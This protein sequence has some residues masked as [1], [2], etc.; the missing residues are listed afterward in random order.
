MKI[1]RFLPKFEGFHVVSKVII[2][3]FTLGWARAIVIF[4]FIF[5][6]NK[7]IWSNTIIRQR[8]SIRIHQQMECGMVGIV[9]YLSIGLI[10]NSWIYA[11]PAIF[12]FYIIYFLNWIINIPHFGGCANPAV[13]FRREAD[14]NANIFGYTI[15]RRP[16][17]WIK[18]II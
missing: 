5:Y 16:F 8:G 12:L 7:Y 2:F 14:R 13:G 6:N 4:P 15:L 1:P 10:W 18:Y 9:L 17:Q 3:I 11:L